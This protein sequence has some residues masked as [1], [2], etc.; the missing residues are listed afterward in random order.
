LAAEEHSVAKL[1][2]VT[3]LKDLRL[4]NLFTVVWLALAITWCLVAIPIFDRVLLPVLCPEPGPTASR[5]QLTD[6]DGTLRNDAELRIRRYTTSWFAYS[7]LW[8]SVYAAF[9]FA[10][11]HVWPRK[12]TLEEDETTIAPKKPAPIDD[13]A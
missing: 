3:D 1:G 11:A 5:L 12:P 4:S 2:Q 13:L 8:I 7:G 10:L 9:T 6:D